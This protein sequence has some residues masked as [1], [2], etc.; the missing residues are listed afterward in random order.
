MKPAARLRELLARPGL[1]R[2]PG[3]YD[4]FSA[5]LIEQSG[6]EV[7]YMTGFGSSASV[8]GLPDAG[9]M[10][11]SEMS[12]H[13]GN[14]A[15][16]LRIPLIADGD[17]GYGNAINAFRTVRTYAQFG[18]AAIQLEDQATPKKCGHTPGKTLIPLKEMIGKLK[19]AFDARAEEDIVIVART[20]ARS[21]EGFKA[22]LERCLAFEEAGADV[23]FFEAPESEQEMAEVAKQVKAPLLA[24][25][26]EGGKTPFLSG[27]RLEDLG[28]KIAIYPSTLL[29]TVARAMQ[30]QLERFQRDDDYQP[31]EE[32]ISFEELKKLVG[33][34]E[35]YR[36]EGKYGA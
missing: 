13:A 30:R 31:F 22:A 23:I 19:A 25:M 24:N 35:Y 11:F 14:I 20:D 32:Q 26:V 8:L 7:A 16:A 1:L 4:A 2:A 10:D 3:C 27:S 9:L 18:V 12:T 15:R 36:M 17:T 21:V 29:K 34:E 6:C 28:F 5:K 33:F